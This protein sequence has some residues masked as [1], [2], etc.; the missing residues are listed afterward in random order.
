VGFEERLEFYLNERTEDLVEQLIANE[1]LLLQLLNNIYSEITDRGHKGIIA[2]DDGF[3]LVHEEADSLISEYSNEMSLLLKLYDNLQAMEKLITQSEQM[4]E[5]DSLIS[6]KQRVER[7][8]DDRS[9]YTKRIYSSEAVIETVEEY[10]S[11]L[12]SLLSIYSNLERLEDYAVDRGDSATVAEVTLQKE[13]IIDLLSK[14]G[15]IGPLTDNRY[16]QYVDEAQK[17]R[18]LVRDFDSTEQKAGA[19]INVEELTNQKRTLLNLLDKDLLDLLV[20]SGYGIPSEP[21]LSDIIYAWKRERIADF[22]ARLAQYQIVKKALIQT[23]TDAERERMLAREIGDA[24]LNYSDGKFLLAEHQLTFILNDFSEYYEGLD[25][26]HFYRAECQFIRGAYSDASTNYKSLLEKFPSS[27]YQAES[28]LR[29]MEM[30]HIF[31]NDLDFYTY[32]KEIQTINND[33]VNAAVFNK[34]YYLAANQ[35]F[36]DKRFENAVQILRLISPESGYYPA[37]RLLLGVVEVNLEHISVAIDIFE[38]LAKTESYPWSDINTAYIRNTALLR[39]GLIYYQRGE[40]T[41]AIRYFDQV[42]QGFDEYDKGLIADAWANLSIGKYETSVEK[43]NEVLLSSLASDYTYEALVLSAHCKRILDQPESALNTYRYVAEAREVMELRKDYDQERRL[44]LDQAGE[45]DRIEQEVLE[46]RQQVFYPEILQ[47]RSAINEFL[48]TIKQRTDRGTRLIQDYYDERVEIIDHLQQLDDIVEWAEAENRLDLAQ[49]AA[50]Q[51]L[52]LIK[53][54][55]TYKSDVQIVNVSYLVDYPLAAK[56]SNV[57]YRQE[58]LG[59]F[60]RELQM[61]TRR[62]ENAITTAN[63]MTA[64]S[65]VGSDLE[66]RM[67]LEFLESE[68]SDLRTR[69]DRFRHWLLETTPS[70]PASDLDHWSDLSGFGMSDIVHEGRKERLERIDALNQNITSIDRALNQRREQLEAQLAAFEKRLYEM[71]EEFLSRRIEYDKQEH[72]KYFENFYFDTKEREEED[73]ENRLQNLMK[74]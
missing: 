20:Q 55:E 30:S 51:R 25:A 62:L 65:K 57:A 66:A 8:L 61:E 39:L 64:A 16:D 47:I 59:S 73:W 74:P 26:V 13:R 72:Q 52:R 22:N 41:H 70:A 71:Q 46:R 42:S 63:S 9:L 27:S 6:V 67:D 45:L 68:L 17:I 19:G 5:L 11:E 29:L 28:L 44:V 4:Q 49:E 36:T 53:I 33:T 54:L 40:Y 10:T 56:E 50:I 1:T 35:M 37:A 14:W 60:Y 58:I 3:K 7:A 38:D 43:S 12:D 34:A 18:D 69:L 23:A 2:G 15:T 32:F 48:M 31:E 24:L 21:R